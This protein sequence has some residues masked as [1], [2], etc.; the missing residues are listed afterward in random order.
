MF[1][2]NEEDRKNWSAARTA[3]KTQGGNLATIPNKAVQAFLTMH[4]KN[5]PVDSWIG[6]HDIIEEG[7]FLWTDGSSVRYTNWVSGAPGSSHHRFYFHFNEDC[8]TMIKEPE[9][10]A[11]NWKNRKCSINYG[12]ICQKNTAQ[13]LRVCGQASAWKVPQLEQWPGGRDS[14]PVTDVDAAHIEHWMQKQFYV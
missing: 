13:C 10:W 6:L 12:Y 5:V 1:G 9:K 7:N 11:G 14:I 2:F 4:F 8:V 3:C